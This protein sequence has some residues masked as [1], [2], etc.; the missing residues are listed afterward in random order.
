L[1]SWLVSTFTRGCVGAVRKDKM[2]GGK[3]NAMLEL[4]LEDYA[5]FKRLGEGLV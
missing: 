4:W 1:G 3:S 5:A 2:K